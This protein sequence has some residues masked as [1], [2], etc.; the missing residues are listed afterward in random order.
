MSEGRSAAPSKARV[1]FALWPDED[2]QARLLRQ[3][4]ELHRRLHGKL[5]RQ[6]SIHLTLAF[7]GD[8]TSEGL[9]L[10]NEAAAGAQ[11]DSFALSVDRGG[12]WR[13]NNVGWV[14][15]SS[16]PDALHAL[17]NSLADRLRA[18]GFELEDRPYSPHITLVR[19]AHCRPL[20]LRLDAVE[21]PVR[22]FVLVE[23]QLDALGSRYT[24]IG[25]WPAHGAQS[26]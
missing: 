21:W 22:D 4:C 13:H 7:L 12:C 5:T 25:R 11:F 14:A 6:E 23:S 16:V 3:G 9:V 8:V 2:I 19:K 1:F 26:V 17:A 24:V 15:P 18:A 10:A 20:D